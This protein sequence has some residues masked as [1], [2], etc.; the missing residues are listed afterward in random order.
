ME[1]G[2]EDRVSSRNAPFSSQ[3]QELYFFHELSP[4]SCFFLPRGA[5]VYNKLIEFIRSEYRRRGFQEVVSPNIYN[6]KLWKTSGHWDHYAVSCTVMTSSL[7]H[8]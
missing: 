4:G 8:R 6:S 5:H 7:H 1:G 3:D 2:R